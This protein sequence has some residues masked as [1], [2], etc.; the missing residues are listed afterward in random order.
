MS[1]IIA[2][3][4][5]KGGVG[6]TTSAVSIA[7]ELA[8]GGSRV[9][10]VD[11]DPQGNATSGLGVTPNEEGGDLYDMFFDRV[12]LRD[13]LKPSVMEGLMVAPSSQDLVSIELELGKVPGRELILKSEIALLRSRFDYILIDC[14]PS[15]GLLTLNALGAADSILIPLQ[16]EYYALEGISG[17]LNTINFVQQTFNPSL[18]MLGV[19]LTMYDGR[20][21]LSS[22]VEEEARN[23]FGDLIFKERIPRN[24]RLSESP[25]HGLPICMYA[26]GSSG[27]EAYRKLT[28]EIRERCAAKVAPPASGVANG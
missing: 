28:E 22:Q 26:P 8:S 15:S 19:F 18:T 25:S 20:T 10:L 7:A 12:A 1:S 11:F 16:A 6:K 23:Y 2:I 3:S 4:N 14:P 24:I 9:L 27:A 21:N 5:Q 13:I 17:L